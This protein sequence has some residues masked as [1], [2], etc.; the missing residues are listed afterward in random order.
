MGSSAQEVRVRGSVDFSFSY[1]NIK[2][3]EDYSLETE[4][5]HDGVRLDVKKLKKSSYW[6]I[7][8]S[9]NDIN[10]DRQVQI[11][12]RRTTNGNGNGYVWG[13][14]NYSEVRNMPATFMQGYG[15]L[16]NIYLQYKLVGISME[17]PADT[18]YTD[19]VYTIY[20]Q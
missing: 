6:R 8:V 17:L 13:G 16:N 4:S 14:Q 1:S 10:W 5:K 20:E 12:V 15:I 9:K 7:A 11:Y 18:Y 19:I 3:G 2:A